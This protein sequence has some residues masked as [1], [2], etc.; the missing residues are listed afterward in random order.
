MFSYPDAHRYRVGPNYFQLPPNRPI[1]KC[2]APY[3]RDGPGTM[4]GNYGGDADYVFSGVRPVAVSRRV[5]MPTHELY[6]GHVGVFATSVTDTDFVQARELWQIICREKDGE[7]EFL[8]N[9]VPTLVGVPPKLQQQVVGEFTE[10]LTS[11]PVEIDLLL[12]LQTILAVLMEDSKIFSRRDFQT[13]PST[14]LH[15]SY[16]AIWKLHLNP[17]DST[18]EDYDDDGGYGPVQNSAAPSTDWPQSTE[19]QHRSLDNDAPRSSTPR[20]RGHSCPWPTA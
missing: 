19:P 20:P 11:N 10:L 4:N 3:V 12:T 15:S 8:Q 7:T 6:T 18:V 2:Y 13:L 14:E 9:V 17:A 16:T 1:N 5:Q